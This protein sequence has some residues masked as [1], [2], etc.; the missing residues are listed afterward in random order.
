[1]VFSVLYYQCQF[2]TEVVENNSITLNV[3]PPSD[4]WIVKTLTDNG[5][6]ILDKLSSDGVYMIDKV[7]E[8]KSVNASFSYE[9]HIQFVDLESSGMSTV[10]NGTN[11]TINK[12]PPVLIFLT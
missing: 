6:D 4:K 8:S 3:T 11:I 12:I 1:M 7:N 10:L 2:S 9:G 5:K